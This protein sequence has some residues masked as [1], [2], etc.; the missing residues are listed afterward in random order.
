[1]RADTSSSPTTGGTDG[2]RADHRHDERGWFVSA[3]G[4]NGNLCPVSC[5]ADTTGDVILHHVLEGAGPAVLLL[6]STATDAR[7]WQPQ[8]RDLRRDF[9]VVAPDLRGYGRSPLTSAPFSHAGDLVRLLDHL[10]IDHCAVVGSSGGGAV[11]LQV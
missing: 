10:H 4:P 7:Q 3:Y 6:H 11:A 5:A 8:I 2:P 1:M 9:T